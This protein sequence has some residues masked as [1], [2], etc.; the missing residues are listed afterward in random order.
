MAP[1]GARSGA[2]WKRSERAKHSLP[3]TVATPSGMIVLMDAVATARDALLR[4]FKWTDG[5]ADF[6]AVLREAEMLASLGPALA[7]PFAGAGVTVVVAIEARGFILG[8]LCAERLGVGLV[9]ARKD[10]SVLPGEKVA[11]R[12]A[13]DWRGRQVAL[14][15]SRVLSSRDKVLIVDDWIETGSQARAVAEAIGLCGAELV[16]TS[17]LVDDTTATVRSA[18]NLVALIKKEDIPIG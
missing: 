6:G 15:V 3:C 8:A 11:V 4:T 9:L 10:G 5:H 12:S 1:R 17:V 16:G 13:P 14:R 2:P 7:A 18:L